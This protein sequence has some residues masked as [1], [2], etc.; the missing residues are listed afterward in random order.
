LVFPEIVIGVVP[1]FV[2]LTGISSEPPTVTFPKLREQGE[3]TSCEAVWA[4]AGPI[5]TKVTSAARS[6]GKRDR[7][8]RLSLGEVHIMLVV[9]STLMFEKRFPKDWD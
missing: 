9:L 1:E 2:K 4:D 7:L 8:R 3:H 6:V 5:S